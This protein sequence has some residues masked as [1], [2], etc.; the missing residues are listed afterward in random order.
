MKVINYKTNLQIWGYICHVSNAVLSGGVRRAAL[1]YEADPK[2]MRE[3][4]L[5][6]TGNWRT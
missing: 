5:Q 2:M 3:I 6:K 1:D 4:F